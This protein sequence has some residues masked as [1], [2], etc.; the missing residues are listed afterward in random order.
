P[1]ISTP[2]S[3]QDHNLKVGAAHV[4]DYKKAAMKSL[5]IKENSSSGRKVPGWRNNGDGTH[6]V[7]SKEAN[8]WNL[9]GPNWK[10]L[11]G[12]EGDPTK[13]HVG[14][15]V[16]KKIKVNQGAGD[17]TVTERIELAKGAGNNKFS[18][19]NS[20]YE[21][22][23]ET[24][25]IKVD[26]NDK[27]ALIEAADKFQT[28]ETLNDGYK[29]QGYCSDGSYR[30]YSKFSELSSEI[31]KS[32]WH[33]DIFL[34]AEIDIAAGLGV[35]GSISLVVDLDNWKDSGINFSGGVAAGLN[36]GVGVG[37]GYTPRDLEGS[38]PV[39]VDGNFGCL[40]FSIAA[41]TDEKGFNGGSFSFGPGMGLS[42]STQKSYTLSINNIIDFFN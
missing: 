41:M 39:G 9:Y 7:I 18:N 27:K 20:G 38:M 26:L 3:Q 12:Y 5:G 16:G 28:Y 37:I 8:L 11:S 31:Y 30:T 36:V 14:D 17:M 21:I 34:T 33:G 32:P 15:T 1:Q 42:S 2:V 19:T 13:L 24:K 29:L 23:H 22:D 25:T 4:E 6:T 35:E 40:P 10:E